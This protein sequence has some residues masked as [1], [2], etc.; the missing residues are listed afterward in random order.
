MIGKFENVPLEEETVVIF[1]SEAKLGDYEL[2]YQ[3]WYW[4]GITAESFIFSDDDVVQLSDNELT[5][6]AKESPLVE[7]DSQ[8]TLSRK[9]NGFTFV[10]FNFKTE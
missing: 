2:L 9:S 4:D 3:K 1:E 5:L 10:N 8:L 7:A 6:L